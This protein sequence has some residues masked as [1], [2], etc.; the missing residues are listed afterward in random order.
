MKAETEVILAVVAYSFCSGTLVLLNKLILHH[1]PYPSLVIA[2]QLVAALIFIGVAKSSE[3]LKVD[4]I[5]WVYVKPYLVYTVAF[6]LGVF[7]N[8][9]SLS[10]SNVETVIVFRALSPCIVSFLD[11]L[12]LGREYPSTRSWSALALIVLGTY[13]YASFDVKFQ[14]Q[15]MAAYVWPVLYLFVISFEMAYG[16]KIIKS[17]DLKTLSGPVLY[18]NVRYSTT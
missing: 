6:S 5:K 3:L 11:A 17:V 18:T 14:T 9:K 4:P 7:C 13:G 1:L 16:K 2:I 10:I 12:F 15:G 8:M